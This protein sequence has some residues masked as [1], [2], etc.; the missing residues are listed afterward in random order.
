MI[1]LIVCL[2]NAGVLQTQH[3]HVHLNGYVVIDEC[4]HSRVDTKR[5]R[6][7]LL[8]GSDNVCA[9]AVD[10][11]CLTCAVC[12][13]RLVEERKTFRVTQRD[14]VAIYGHGREVVA[15]RVVVFDVYVNLIEADVGRVNLEQIAAIAEAHTQTHIVAYHVA[16]HRA[17]GKAIAGRVNILNHQE[18]VVR[19]LVRRVCHLSA[20]HP[21]SL[22]DEGRGVKVKASIITL[23]TGAKHARETQH[24]S[25]KNQFSHSESEFTARRRIL[26]LH[27]LNLRSSQLACL[28]V[29]KQLNIIEV[30]RTFSSCKVIAQST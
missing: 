6:V 9:V 21:R 29:V 14:V 15:Q 18:T 7:R 20:D 26:L 4:N 27:F 17:Y 16:E 11:F 13:L 30:H 28:I 5:H 25:Y 23:R 24:Y 2:V 8:V 1:D 3:S 19:I 22:L 10:K 12:E